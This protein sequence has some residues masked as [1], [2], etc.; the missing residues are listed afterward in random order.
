MRVDGRNLSLTIGTLEIACQS[1]SAVLDNEDAD[2][3]LTTFADVVAGTDRR[4]FLTITALPDY[5]PASF[6]TLLWETPA[7][8]PV[9]Y[10]LKPYNNTAAASV[11]QPWFSGSATL[12]QP[13]PL[14]GDAGATWS[15]TTR[16]T[17]TGRPVRV[18]L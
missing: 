14:G 18:T 10:L 7:F 3:D 17:C 5:A 12:D 13:P 15:F 2:A 9:G 11:E 1:S 6:W 4:W 8:T 16:L